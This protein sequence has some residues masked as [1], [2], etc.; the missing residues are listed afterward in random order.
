MF[1]LHQCKY[2][3]MKEV[4]RTRESEGA[5]VSSCDCNIINNI[6]RWMRM[7]TTRVTY[8]SAASRAPDVSNAN[9]IFE[10]LR[11][12]ATTQQAFPILNN[13]TRR[14][15]Q[16]G[17]RLATLSFREIESILAYLIDDDVLSLFLRNKSAPQTAQDSRKPSQ[18]RNRARLMMRE[19]FYVHK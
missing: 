16:R 17:G 9:R 7:N 12:Q 13:R 10:S 19:L 15:G 2:K 1:L 11:P 3:I 6:A 14:D 18:K 8:F 5:K 4:G